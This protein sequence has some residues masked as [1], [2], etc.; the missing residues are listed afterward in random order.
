[1]SRKG[2][3]SSFLRILF[4]EIPFRTADDVEAPVTEWALYIFV[5]IPAVAITCFMY[6]D[7][8]E[9]DTDL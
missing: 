4:I 2:P 7:K 5:S 8:V 3:V 6:L 1:M 9:V